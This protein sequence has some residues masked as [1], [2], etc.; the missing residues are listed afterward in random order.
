M[1]NIT[2]IHSL[3]IPDPYCANRTEQRVDQ[4]VDQS[5]DINY[6]A[7]LLNEEITGDNAVQISELVDE[8]NWKIDNYNRSYIRFSRIWE[9]KYTEHYNFT[10]Q[11]LGIAE[12]FIESK[13]TKK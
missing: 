3:N 10:Y 4:F 1:A 11:I 13:P 5:G 8:I 12:Q 9:E 7:V 6:L 2:Y